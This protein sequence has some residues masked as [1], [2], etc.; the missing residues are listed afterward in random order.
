[1]RLCVWMNAPIPP[2]HIEQRMNQS[3][4]V[5]LSPAVTFSEAL[6]VWARIGLL[7]FGGPAGQIALMHRILVDE[8]KW[9]NEPQFLHA[10]NFCMLLPG[11][12]AQQLATYSGW[13]LHGIRGG[14]AAGLLF[15]LPGVFVM[16]GL[17]MLYA[18]YADLAFV[19]ALFFG[20]KAAVFAVVIEALVRIARRMLK[21]RLLY[22]LAGAAFIA[23]FLFDVPFPAVVLG[24]AL[25]GFA[26]S[27][28]WPEIFAGVAQPDDDA[29]EI[30]EAP[31][32][33]PS[34]GRAV[35]ALV[36]GLA[37]WWAPVAALFLVFGPE[38]VFTQEA[39]FFSKMAVVTFGGAYAVL[40]YVAQEAVTHFG[41]L[42]PGQM[43]DGLGLAETTPG[44]LI[45]VLQF[46][47][48]M[49]AFRAA[50]FADPMLAG[51]AGALI[52]TW[53]TFVPCFLWIFVAAPY[54]EHVRKVKALSAALAAI[55]AAV[56]GVI[57]NLAVWFGLHVVFGRVGELHAYGMRL[58]QPELATLDPW[59]LVLAA[60]ALVA[61]LR[62][63]V[64]MMPVLATSA[65]LGLLIR[66]M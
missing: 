24:S 10:L 13:L 9:L 49:A 41:W 27:R 40:A 18:A 59:A 43:L 38:H 20:I 26:A 65:G 57:L 44:P 30:V 42:A 51:I 19:D 48:Y 1:M 5:V 32:T 23:I 64:G 3:R 29:A 15:I 17:S 39:V 22:A 7:S 35:A 62:F 55:T 46:V 16:L 47:G 45:M 12:E 50:H 31:H 56:V 25:S 54:V 37:L 61:M 28:V 8:R 63:R 2:R 11:P 14:L 36:A 53:V 58:W 52:T 4:T 21:S 34:P 33:H 60:G 6:R 66:L